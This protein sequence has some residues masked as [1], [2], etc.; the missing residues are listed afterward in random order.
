MKK[1]LPVVF[2][3][4]FAVRLAAQQAS[5]SGVQFISPMLIGVGTDRN[6][7]VD[8]TNPNE[9]LLILSLPPSVQNGAPDIRPKMVDSN[10]FTLTLPKIAYVNDS[11]RHEFVATWLPQFDIYKQNFGQNAM[12]QQAIVGLNYFAAKNIQISVGDAY[13]TTHDPARLLQNVFLM[14]PLGP[15]KENAIRAS[16]DMQPNRVTS[17]GVRYDTVRTQFE[18]TDPFQARLLDAHS[19]SFTFNLTR[20]LNRKHRLRGLYSI[21]KVVPIDTRETGDD[22]VDVERSFEKPGHAGTLQYKF[23]LSPATIIEVAGG[24]IK[25]DTGW[26]YT[27][28]GTIDKRISTYFWVGGGYARTLTFL[29]PSPAGG[30]APGVGSN[31]FYDVLVFSF[32]GQ[33]TRKTNIQLAGTLSMA[34]TSRLIETDKGAMGRSRFDYRLSDRTVAFASFETFQQNRNVFVQSPLSRNRFT[35]GI[36]I[37][38]STEAQRRTNALNDDDKYVALTDHARRR[39]NPDQEN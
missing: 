34:N 10:F 38:F 5:T 29:N 12:S 17:L 1:L 13:R 14:L 4:S 23:A 7:L 37:S 24:L 20:M 21:F 3:L 33:P 27:V 31:G 6:F 9:K 18:Q 16:V 32:N 11:R 8:R 30:F 26:N 35:T 36:E 25:L 2:V 15:F 39:N 22:A 28:R 19:T